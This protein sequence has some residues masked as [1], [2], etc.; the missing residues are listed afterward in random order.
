[1]LEESPGK[2]GGRGTGGGV[3]ATPRVWKPTTS[4]SPLTIGRRPP[5]GVGDGDRGGGGWH[6]ACLG[7]GVGRP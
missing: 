3:G 2:E 6:K 7:G 4:P 5:V 1:M